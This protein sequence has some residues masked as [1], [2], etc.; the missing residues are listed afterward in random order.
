MHEVSLE[1]LYH[2]DKKR[3]HRFIHQDWVVADVLN[4]SSFIHYRRH[5]SSSFSS[6]SE[7]CASELLENLLRIDSS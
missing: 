5:K 7:S 2:H 6:N 1:T 4:R 3:S